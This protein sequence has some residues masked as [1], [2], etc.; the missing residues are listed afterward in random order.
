[1]RVIVIGGSGHIGSYL[2]PRLV[3][4]EHEVV[5]ITRGKQVPYFPDPCWNRVAMIQLDREQEDAANQFGPK[6]RDLKPDIVIDLV[7]YQVESARQMVEAVRGQ[8]QLFLHCGT[9]WVHGPTVEAPTTEEQPRH[10]FGTY[11]IQKA[12]IEAYLLTE[13]HRSGFPAVILHPGHIVGRGWWP[14]NPAGNFN[15]DVFRRL[16]RGEEIALPNLGLETVQHV[17]ADDVAQGFMNAMAYRS[18]AIG[19]SF[20]IV[21]EK[22]LTLRG[23]AQAVARWFGQPAQLKFLAWETWKDQFSTAD[24]A[25][26]WDHIAHSPNCSIEKARKF[27]GYQPRY[28]GLQAVAESIEFFQTRGLLEVSAQPNEAGS[29][30][31]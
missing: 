19:E 15:P 3:A 9:I 10:P 18:A 12:A 8:V 17:H 20:H 2:V 26:T 21:A 11:G 29:G 31:L 25:A 30:K 13:A 28:S 7:C 14:L 4:A 23:Y 1:M 5:C 6:I 27:I 22:A 16:A 24:A